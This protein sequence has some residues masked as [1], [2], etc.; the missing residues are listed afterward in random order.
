MNIT[1]AI[2]TYNRLDYLKQLISALKSQSR[3]PD[4]IVVINNSSTDGTA[5]YLRQNPDI[6]VITQGNYGSSGGQFTAAKYCY[7]S[8]SEWIW[9]MDDDVIPAIN[10]LENLCKDLSQDRIHVPL[11]INPDGY[12]NQGDTLLLN[13]KN[14]FK[15]VWAKIIDKEIPTV[16]QIEAQGITFEG[17][18]FHKS[19]IKHIGLP[20]FNFFIYGDD[21]DY[22]S[23]AVASGYRCFIIS[24]AISNRLLPVPVDY[25]FD[26]KSYYVV[27]NQIALDVLNAPLYVRII[28]PFGYLISWLIRASKLSEYKTV[29]KAFSD[30]YFY[31]SNPRNIEFNKKYSIK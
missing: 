16:K 14:P 11:R 2:V 1:A 12:V 26:W 29:L 30:G 13:Y 9:L 15:S 7:E 19:L 5:D 25:K 22:F 31:K 17:P 20:E 21:T 6:E 4:R 27:R 3:V 18:L 23:R 24:S 10:C 8:G 28:R